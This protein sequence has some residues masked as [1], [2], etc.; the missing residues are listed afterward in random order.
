MSANSDLM[1]LAIASA[2]IEHG[3][4]LQTRVTPGSKAIPASA[5]AGVKVKPGN[6]KAPKWS[7]SEDAFLKAALGQLEE[8]DIA[9]ELGRTV[10]AIHL[11]WKRDLGL[12]APSKVPS[13]ITALGAAKALGIDG[14]KTAYWVDVGL[15]PG[16]L[17]PGKRKIRLIERVT[18]MRWACAPV[19]WVYFDIKKVHDP[20]LKR[21]LNL[22]ARRWNDEWWT[23]REVAKYH[24]VDPRMVMLSVTLGRLQAFRPPVSLGGRNYGNTWRFSFI[25]KSEA[26]R[27][28]FHFPHRG[29]D[30]SHLTPRGKAWIE[31]ALRMGMNSVDI[32]RTMK[33]KDGTVNIWIHRNFPDFKF[34]KGRAAWSKIH[35]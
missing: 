30:L 6:A 9:R 13:V 33:R 24:H 31:K 25:L 23:T 3:R 34:P 21:L 2:E 14:H 12:T 8:E 15:I 19:N 26:T 10:I 32:G 7:L 35:G 5:L 17:M 22:E 16:R 28:G 1:D 20:H 4:A 18:F 11:H 29:D 27:P